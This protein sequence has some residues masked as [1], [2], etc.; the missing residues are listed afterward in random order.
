ML[1]G[2]TIPYSK[3]NGV[4]GRVVPLNDW[5][6]AGSSGT[7]GIGAWELTGRVS[8]IDLNDEG[9]NGRRLTDF[10]VGCNWYWNQYTKLQFNYI[11]SRLDDNSFGLSH[12]NT[13]AARAQL[14]F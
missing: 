7:S 12:A 13:F 1:T 10:T 4:F 8:H 5:N 3:K 11:N 9:I 6:P 14:D 2:E